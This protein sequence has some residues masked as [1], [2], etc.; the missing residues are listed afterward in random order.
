MLNH[1]RR[2]AVA[3]LAL[4]V[5]MGGT[6]YAAVKL[7]ANSVKAK[8]IAAGA[9]RSSEVKDGSLKSG[10]FGA[11]QLAAG[12]T[13]PPGA[14]GAPGTPGTPGTPGA[15]GVAFG[16]TSMGSAPTPEVPIE[17]GGADRDFTL[18]TAG[19]TYVQFYIGSV[20]TPTCSSGASHVGLYVDGVGVAN[21]SASIGA[22]G[23]PYLLVG[24]IVLTAG[25]HT[26]QAR[27]YCSGA[28]AP[29]GASIGGETALTVLALQG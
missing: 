15:P 13:G 8:Q 29:S 14:P 20:A 16:A 26:A 9:V 18:P 10:D 28:A 4:F 12:P 17:G 23:S 5:A 21:A 24:T 27:V 25:A 6:S 22:T 1:L 3:Y 19:K 11:G 7:P 2:N